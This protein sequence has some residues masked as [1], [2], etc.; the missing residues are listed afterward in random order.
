LT[1]ITLFARVSFI[2]TRDTRSMEIRL[3][4][5]IFISIHETRWERSFSPSCRMSL[6][7]QTSA[8]L[9]LC[10][11]DGMCKKGS[12]QWLQSL[13][14]EQRF[15]LPNRKLFTG[16]FTLQQIEFH[17]SANSSLQNSYI[18][19]SYR[20]PLWRSHWR[21]FNAVSTHYKVGDI[22]SYPI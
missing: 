1:R 22:R 9:L 10:F 7:G 18:H 4:I 21:S 20:L 6:M 11:G 17:V 16:R 5:E 2:R 12:S 13:L 14:C 19:I 8:L 3:L 15:L